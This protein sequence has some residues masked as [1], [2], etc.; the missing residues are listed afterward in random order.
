M[1]VLNFSNA[2]DLLDCLLW[3]YDNAKRL[4]TIVEGMQADFDGN[5]TEFWNN[6]Y[7]NVFDLRTANSFGLRVWGETMGV[8]RPTYTH[9]GVTKPYSDD[10]YRLFLQSRILMF[11]MNGSTYDITKYLLNMFPNKP[12]IIVDNLDMTLSYIL[13]WTPTDEE[14][15][16][17]KNDDFLPRPSGVGIK[18]Y[19]VDPNNIFGFDGSLLNGFDQGTFFA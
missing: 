19:A 8:D 1:K 5:T 15:Y 14:W 12:V 18:L 2:C 9:D 7:T 13:Y 4:Q 3:Q 11:N 17:L 6:F 10:M 16:V